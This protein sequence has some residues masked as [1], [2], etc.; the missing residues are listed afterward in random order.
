MRS[1][2]G[3][4]EHA[5]SFDLSIA[6]RFRPIGMFAVCSHGNASKLRSFA[7][8]Q[9]LSRQWFSN[10]DPMIPNDIKQVAKHCSGSCPR[11]A[12]KRSTVFQKIANDVPT[13]FRWSSHC[14]QWKPGNF[15]NIPLKSPDD[16]QQFSYVSPMK[17]QC[18]PHMGSND[19]QSTPTWLP[20]DVPNI[21]N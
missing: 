17:F 11:I 15:Q 13:V 2:Y 3:G 21:F 16:V 18:V 4:F 10:D 7:I 19:F 1:M 9:K 12:N 14:F 6:A 8:L 20:N 5:V